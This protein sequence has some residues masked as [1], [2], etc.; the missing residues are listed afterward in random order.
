MMTETEL[1]LIAAAAIIGRTRLASR[2]AALPRVCQNPTAPRA[3]TAHSPTIANG[4]RAERRQRG[5][6][7]GQAQ[8]Q[9][10]YRCAAGIGHAP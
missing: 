10:E 8:G 7:E 6:G 5:S 4:S 2:I 9:G 1:K 3:S